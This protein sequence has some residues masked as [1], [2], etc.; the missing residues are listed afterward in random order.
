MKTAL[1]ADA[2]QSGMPRSDADTEAQRVAEAAPFLHQTCDPPAHFDGHA[3]RAQ[4]RIGAGQ[5]I[6]EDDQ[7]AVAGEM[8]QRSLEAIDRFAETLIIFLQYRDD[9]FRLS[10]FG[11]RGEATQVAEYDGNIA[12]VAF[13]K[14]LIAR[15]HH[16]L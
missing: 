9:V 11:E 8:L 2:A 5:R 14:L 15:R 12:A 7:K 16:E 6:V 1:V 4:R 13:Q 3:H 10:A